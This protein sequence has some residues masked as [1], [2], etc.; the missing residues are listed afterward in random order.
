MS[1]SPIAAG[2][3][4]PRALAESIVVDPPKDRDQVRARLGWRDS[5]CGDG[6]LEVLAGE[7]A[8][9]LG[10]G[11]VIVERIAVRSPDEK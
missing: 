1:S 3:V 2:L 7:A 6:L 8:L 11:G 9:R 5:L 10:P 4:M